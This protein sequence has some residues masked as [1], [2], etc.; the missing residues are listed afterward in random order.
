MLD[1]HPYRAGFTCGVERFSTRTLQLPRSLLAVPTTVG[2]AEQ[3]KRG[4]ALRGA[5][6]CH[7]VP[8][9]APG[10]EHKRYPCGLRGVQSRLGLRKRMSYERDELL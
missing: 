1:G 10:T 2:E 8:T 6:K 3:G 4:P 7:C 9:K 5:R